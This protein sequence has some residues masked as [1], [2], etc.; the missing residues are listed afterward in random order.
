MFHQFVK[1]F[2]TCNQRVSPSTFI[3]EKNFRMYIVGELMIKAFQEPWFRFF[4]SLI[5]FKVCVSQGMR[6]GGP[7]NKNLS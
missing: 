5:F 7:K 3:F 6:V 2:G 4:F 1:F